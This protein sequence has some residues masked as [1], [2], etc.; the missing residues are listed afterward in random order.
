MG[1]EVTD[2]TPH[3]LG[4]VPHQIRGYLPHFQQILCT[5]RAYDKCSAC[6]PPILAGYRERGIEFLLDCLRS[7][8]FI[9][10][11]TGL[12]AMFAATDLEDVGAW[13][14]EEEEAPVQ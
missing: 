4:L 7:P 2:P 12:T 3:P 1:Q 11:T 8:Q 13:G 6:S 9:E 14:E 10:D 5:A